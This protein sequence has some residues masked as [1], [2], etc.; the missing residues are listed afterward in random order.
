MASAASDKERHN[1]DRR[2]GI[3]E[4]MQQM[5]TE[6]ASSEDSNMEETDTKV[7]TVA[8]EKILK[9]HVRR[10]KVSGN[11]D[12]TGPSEATVNVTVVKRIG[13]KSTKGPRMNVRF[14]TMGPKSKC[15]RN[16]FDSVQ[17]VVDN[18]E[19]VS[20]PVLSAEGRTLSIF[21]SLND[22]ISKLPTSKDQ[23]V[24]CLNFIKQR[25]IKKLATPPQPISPVARFKSGLSKDL[26]ANPRLSS[27]TKPRTHP[28][29]KR[30]EL[31]DI[32]DITVE[33]KSGTS[34]IAGEINDGEKS[35]DSERPVSMP[36]LLPEVPLTLKE[37][38]NPAHSDE[39]PDL[40][41][42]DD[43]QLKVRQSRSMVKVKYTSTHE[44][45]I[46]HPTNKPRVETIKF[47]LSNVTPVKLTES[48][49]IDS[50]NTMSCGALTS[51]TFNISEIPDDLEKK[52][53]D[54]GLKVKNA[55][56]EKRKKKSLKDKLLIKKE[57][58]GKKKSPKKDQSLTEKEV[59]EASSVETIKK[60]K[61]TLKKRKSEIVATSTDVSHKLFDSIVPPVKEKKSHIKGSIDKNVEISSV[62]HIKESIDR[63]VEVSGV[64]Q[65]VGSIDKTLEVSGVEGEVPLVITTKRR[66][67]SCQKNEDGTNILGSKMGQEE[68]AGKNKGSVKKRMKCSKQDIANSGSVDHFEESKEL[69]FK[70]DIDPMVIKKIKRR[71]T[72]VWQ[73]SVISPLMK[74]KE[75][76]LSSSKSV[77]KCKKKGKDPESKTEGTL[78]E[79]TGETVIHPE[80]SEHVTIPKSL[81]KTKSKKVGRLDKRTLKIISK[82]ERGLVKPISE[83]QLEG[84]NSSKKPMPTQTKR[85]S[86][87][88]KPSLT[89]SK[90]G[91]SPGKPSSTLPKMGNSSEKPIPTQPE[92]DSSPEKP[93]LT[94]SKRGRSPDKPSPTPSKKDISPEKLS[95]TQPKRGR[96]PEKSTPSEREGS[97]ET[98]LSTLSKRSCSPEKPSP[99]QPKRDGSSK[100]PS[101]TQLK[102]GRSPKKLTATL[103]KRSISPGKNVTKRNST[104]KNA[105]QNASKRVGS[106]EKYSPEGTTWS[107]STPTSPVTGAT[108]RSG[109]TIKVSSKAQEMDNSDL[110]FLMSKPSPS[111][112]I[113]SPVRSKAKREILFDNS[114]QSKS[115]MKKEKSQRKKSKK[116]HK[117]KQ[118][119]DQRD[120][121]RTEQTDEI[122]AS[123]D[124][125]EVTK[126]I[127][128]SKVP[129][130]SHELE[131]SALMKFLEDA[132]GDGKTWEEEQSEQ[133]ERQKEIEVLNRGT[134]KGEETSISID[135]GV[136]SH[137]TSDTHIDK[138]KA[139]EVHSDSEMPPEEQSFS[140]I[141]ELSR[142]ILGP[143]TDSRA[144]SDQES[145]KGEPGKKNKDVVEK[146]L[147]QGE[148][149]T[150]KSRSVGILA[151]MSNNEQVLAAATNVIKKS[152]KENNVDNRNQQMSNS[153][154]TL[155]SLIN[156]LKS[157]LP[158]PVEGAA[159]GNLDDSFISSAE[160]ENIKSDTDDGSGSGDSDEDESEQDDSEKSDESIV[161]D[162]IDDILEYIDFAVKQN[163]KKDS[164]LSLV[165]DDKVES[166]ELS[167]AEDEDKSKAEDTDEDEDKSKAVDSDEDEVRRKL[168]EKSDESTVEDTIFDILDYIDFAERQ[169]KKKQNI[170]VPVTLTEGLHIKGEVDASNQDSNN[171]TNSEPD[172]TGS[173]RVD[174][175]NELA[176]T[177][178]AP[179]R[180]DLHTLSTSMSTDVIHAGPSTEF[181][182]ASS[183]TESMQ[184]STLLLQGSAEDTAEPKAHEGMDEYLTQI[185]KA[186]SLFVKEQI[187]KDMESHYKNIRDELSRKAYSDED[188]LVKNIMY[189]A[190]ENVEKAKKDSTYQVSPSVDLVVPSRSGEQKNGS[191]FV[192]S[193]LDEYLKK[194]TWTCHILQ[195]GMFKAPDT[196]YPTNKQGDFDM[197]VDEIDGIVFYSFKDNIDLNAHIAKEMPNENWRV[198]SPGNVIKRGTAFLQTVK[199]KVRQ[200][201][202]LLLKDLDDEE[203]NVRKTSDM[204]KVKGWRKRYPDDSLDGNTEYNI[205]SRMSGQF[206]NERLVRSLQT[207]EL[208][209]MGLG[210]KR[211]RRRAPV[212]SH[213]RAVLPKAQLEMPDLTMQNEGW[214]SVT[215]ACTG[216][217]NQTTDMSGFVGDFWQAE[218]GLSDV[219]KLHITRIYGRRPD[220]TFAKKRTVF[221]GSPRKR[222][223]LMTQAI[224]NAKQIAI[225]GKHP[226]K[227]DSINSPVLIK[228][229]TQIKTIN[230]K[231]VHN[232]LCQKNNNPAS[233]QTR[234]P[235]PQIKPIEVSSSMAVMAAEALQ[236]G[237]SQYAS[238]ITPQSTDDTLCQKPGLYTF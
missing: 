7:T 140:A 185:E 59:D 191:A 56:K 128:E 195:T 177:S 194:N 142:K 159:T 222:R 11:E 209:S 216:L 3:F 109:R 85:G 96:S 116:V 62:S 30:R 114:S 39:A 178:S 201:N 52:D 190:K 112:E 176:Q 69:A 188:V 18:K 105:S 46:D 2:L 43:T 207:H 38:V 182:L 212:F 98:P 122:A 36:K 160:D 29:S 150:S 75:E 189:A 8:R 148:L 236:H 123:V 64:S 48:D 233:T 232:R 135:S 173:A 99:T 180:A 152:R 215:A 101:P 218:R 51:D 67:R 83:K 113:E 237:T 12:Q 169:N 102:R 124:H 166:D 107:T 24:V 138:E 219:Q 225:H 145:E 65:F 44:S 20:M 153:S 90:R 94:L 137:M 50:K 9:K 136:E 158:E 92:R 199:A 175:S 184:V 54:S 210:L 45:K 227:Q 82:N 86:S 13:P 21:S 78:T 61:K 149:E 146:E 238:P 89:L 130:S 197:D 91:S 111:S 134:S 60:N 104:G 76:D 220:G 74:A 71:S 25:D 40:T 16:I 58:D 217:D 132:V 164:I 79:V 183:S 224:K 118:K 167:K 26:E 77:K 72:H 235:W 192:S 31:R 234:K 33:H 115:G 127:S 97:P 53:D 204:S 117:V 32:S 170:L 15:T 133:L 151:S 174:T 121:V 41:T 35:G 213:K 100:K 34:I 203:E 49:V 103:P 110:K 157:K 206:M 223:N 84:H 228:D 17:Q 211:K 165:A 202:D 186:T 230:H 125:S 47:D 22:A 143:D 196:K 162:T 88:E 179:A 147:E 119:V 193:R 95:P 57:G 63:T 168:N 93:L 87:S 129:E 208:K 172:V 231:L 28:R 66:K 80:E 37:D 141:D 108:T 70:V 163:E 5:V 126:D 161:E 4:S 156:R 106:P 42:F 120:E 10:T 55:Q 187:I 229:G 73:D 200:D 81:V 6:A 19:D 205:P 14:K 68:G 154:Q 1:A 27:K 155:S 214:T 131:N 226:A 198:K 139:E 144:T 171:N 221:R 181:A 23:P